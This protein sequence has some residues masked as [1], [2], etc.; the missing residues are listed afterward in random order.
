MLASGLLSDNLSTKTLGIFSYAQQKS[1]MTRKA[2]FEHIPL[3]REFKVIQEIIA[4][5]SDSL[6]LENLVRRLGLKSSRKP[7]TRNLFL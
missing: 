5:V 1:A 6:A 3:R 7:G 4:R 2:M